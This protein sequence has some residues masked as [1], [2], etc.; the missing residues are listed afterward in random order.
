MFGGF[1]GLAKGIEILTNTAENMIRIAVIK[2]YLSQ[3][4]YL[5]K[6]ILR[7]G[8]SRFS[9]NWKQCLINVK[10]DRVFDK[11]EKNRRKEKQKLGQFYVSSRMYVKDP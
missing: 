3:M 8:A 5:T 10:L 4:S 2:V 9:K 11:Y 6:R 1:R 7:F